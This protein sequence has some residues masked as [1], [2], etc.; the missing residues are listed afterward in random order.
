MCV[1][2]RVSVCIYLCVCFYNPI[3]VSDNLITDS[4]K[5]A[6][7]AHALNVAKRNHKEGEGGCEV[8]GKLGPGTK[9]S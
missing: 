3:K 9:R 8:V 7:R 6:Q 5:A 1:C 4:S 2:A